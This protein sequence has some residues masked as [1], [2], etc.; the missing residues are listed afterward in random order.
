MYSTEFYSFVVV[1]SLAIKDLGVQTTAYLSCF[2]SVL[3]SES[4]AGAIVSL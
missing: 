4:K 2:L 1:L 3:H